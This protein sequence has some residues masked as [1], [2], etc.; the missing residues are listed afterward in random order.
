MFSAAAFGD[1]RLL[2]GDKAV[3]KIVDREPTSRV[4]RIPV[5]RPLPRAIDTWDDYDKLLGATS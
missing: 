4:A 1:L 2:H 5:D 3:G